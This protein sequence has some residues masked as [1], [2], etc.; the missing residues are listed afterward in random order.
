MAHIRFEIDQ[1]RS[2]ADKPTETSSE[3]PTRHV[4]TR[5]AQ[6]AG[7]AWGEVGPGWR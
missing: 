2:T 6:V 5:A 3:P 1:Q 4:L 7:V